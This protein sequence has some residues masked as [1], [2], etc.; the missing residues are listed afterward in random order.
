M[1]I[2]AE[3]RTCGESPTVLCVDETLH[4]NKPFCED[5]PCHLLPEYSVLMLL[6]WRL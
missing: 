2:E 1:V 4:F 3:P 5:E 6:S